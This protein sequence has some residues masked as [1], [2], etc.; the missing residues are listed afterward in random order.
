M[1]GLHH[2]AK[3]MALICLDFF[4]R[5]HPELRAPLICDARARRV[6]HADAVGDRRGA[7]AGGGRPGAAGRGAGEIFLK[8]NDLD[9]CQSCL[10]RSSWSE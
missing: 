4:D 9:F 3:T 2:F 5:R 10:S 8:N 7:I 6:C 1:N